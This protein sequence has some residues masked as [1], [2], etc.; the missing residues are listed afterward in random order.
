LL[1]SIRDSTVAGFLQFGVLVWGTSAPLDTL[2]ELA[3]HV[4]GR[5]K[6]LDKRTRYFIPVIVLLFSMHND[7]EFYAWLVEPCENSTHLVDVADLD[8]QPFDTKQLDRVIRRVTNWYKRLGADIRPDT[9]EIDSS[10]C[11]DDEQDD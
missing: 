11:P 2:E 8:F 5:R 7:K 10:Q 6:K 9:A 4:R 3:K 1:C